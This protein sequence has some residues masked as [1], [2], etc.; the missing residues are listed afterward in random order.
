MCTDAFKGKIT[1]FSRI[2]FFSMQKMHKK[3]LREALKTTIESLTA[4]IPTLDPPPL[5]F[6]RSVFFIDRVVE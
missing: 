1:N 6:G 2:F 3:N 4:V 5:S